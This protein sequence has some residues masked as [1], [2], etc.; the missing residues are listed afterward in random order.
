LPGG[1]IADAQMQTLV[2]SAAVLHC[3]HS[4]SAA[5]ES[6]ALISTQQS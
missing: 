2:L 4:R 6:L 3:M 1:L 5:A